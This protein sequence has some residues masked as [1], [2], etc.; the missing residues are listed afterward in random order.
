MRAKIHRGAHEVGGSCIELE[1]QRQRLVL[2]L[3]RPI[4]AARGEQV[5]RP[6]VAGLE[7]P[8]KSLVGLVI[9]HP[10]LDH[11]GL[12]PGIDQT[13]P[14][15]IGEAAYRLLSEASFF[16]GA[17]VPP[18]P[19]AFLRH[20]ESFALGPFTITPFLNDHS[21]FDAY[22]LLVEADG[23]RLFYTGDIRGHGRKR[24]IFE[25]LLR[26]PPADID[27]LL[28]EGTNIREGEEVDER[29]PTEDDVEA[30]VAEV[31]STTPG[32][33]LAVYSPQN[34]DRLVTMFRAAKR[35]G[36]EL[37]VDLYA[38]TIAAATGLD[39]IP[40]A[41]WEGVR[42]YLPKAQRWRIKAEQAFERTN[43]V[44]IA[45]IYPE[46]LSERSGEFVMTFRGS[47]ANEL[48][49]A[50]CLDGARAVWSMWP[51]YLKDVSGGKM[52][53]FLRERGIPLSV[54]HS[55]GHAFVPDLKRLV[56][57]LAPE[58]VVPIHSFAGDRFGELFPRVDRS[59]DGEWWN[60]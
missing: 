22:S 6:P 14:V 46:E 37:V 35:S 24:G 60:V 25:Q 28:M 30:Q 48:A 17:P 27:V 41:S 1:S 15:F 12:S 53:G 5:P 45:R 18:A 47:M 49:A 51:G 20:R 11:Y 29:G 44:R 3:G 56:A 16:T 59:Q 42:V 32:M 21:A 31:A 4:W 7:Q 23:R 58:R 10:H 38:A 40:Q 36:R 33:V 26:T 57:A 19:I 52:Q 9:T 43:A 55:S 34:I 13:V 54:I 2:D 50:R 39:T 8:D